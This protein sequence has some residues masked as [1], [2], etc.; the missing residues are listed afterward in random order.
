MSSLKEI[1]I[2]TLNIIH[3]E[4][5]LDFGLFK[6][7]SFIANVIH[8]I[9]KDNFDFST[10]VVTPGDHCKVELTFTAPELKTVL[11]FTHLDR[12]SKH[13]MLTQ[14]TVLKTFNDSPILYPNSLLISLSFADQTVTLPYDTTTIT[15]RR[16]IP[17]QAELIESVSM[18]EFNQP[19]R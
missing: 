17:H 3:R 15:L 16:K 12:S 14:W 18:I 13:M 19:S 11:T 7:A 10:I 4:N 5:K 8:R 9:Y 6:D 1:P 2:A